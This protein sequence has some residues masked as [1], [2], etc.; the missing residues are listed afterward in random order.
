ML[1][2]GGV[3][4]TASCGPTCPFS[5]SSSTPQNEPGRS[6]THFRSL[7]STKGPRTQPR[8]QAGFSHSRLFCGPGGV[9]CRRRTTGPLQHASSPA[10]LGH[11]PRGRRRHA[12]H[13]LAAARDGAAA[14]QR[15][16]EVGGG[17]WVGRRIIAG[18]CQW[19]GR[20]AQSRDSRG[21]RT[22]APRSPLT[23]RRCPA[24]A[25]GA[26]DRCRVP[27]ALG[28]RRRRPPHGRPRPPQ[29]GSHE[30]GQGT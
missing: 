11:G 3:A 23:H 8:K 27:V 21:T 15:L 14:P 10:A 5:V 22:D 18:R 19:G 6:S 24:P 7:E 9:C 4:N 17:C 2:H 16:A 20:R 25:L 1:L 12:H 30:Q 29:Q 28:R 26:G 13:V